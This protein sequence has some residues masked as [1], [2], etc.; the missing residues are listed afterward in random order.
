MFKLYKFCAFD[1]DIGG[2]VKNLHKSHKQALKLYELL[3]E[4]QAQKWLLKGS[5]QNVSVTLDMFCVVSCYV[6]RRYL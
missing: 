1:G 5:K 6:L 4:F 3:N 2:I